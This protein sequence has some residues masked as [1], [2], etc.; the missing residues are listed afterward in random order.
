MKSCHCANVDGTGGYYAKWSKSV[1][2]R[3]ISCV[4]THV[5]NLKNLTED[6]RGREGKISYSREVAKHKRHLNTENKLRADGGGRVGGG[7]WGKWMMDLEEGTC[8][9]EHWVLYISDESQGSTPE[10]SLYCMLANL[11]INYLK[12]NK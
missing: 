2:E 4:F 8:W 1:R 10:S 11:T 12:I 3:Q 7:K 9:D 5:W 6:H